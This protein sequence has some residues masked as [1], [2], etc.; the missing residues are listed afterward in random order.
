LASS[1]SVR[2]TFCPPSPFS[3]TIALN[4]GTYPLHSYVRKLYRAAPAAATR[5]LESAPLRPSLASD[6]LVR[7]RWSTRCL[8]SHAHE[9]SRCAR[10]LSRRSSKL[11]QASVRGIS[12]VLGVI[13]LDQHVHTISIS[14]SRAISSRLRE[15]IATKTCR[16]VCARKLPHIFNLDFANKILAGA[17]EAGRR[18]WRFSGSRSSPRST[19][20]TRRN[21]GIWRRRSC[22][23]AKCRRACQRPRWE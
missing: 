9:S 18:R 10:R 5:C 21:S 15:S 20:S 14:S 16:C 22:P 7:G 12:H 11:W 2:R 3:T 23:T 6:L 17:P 1:K 4:V 8:L 19:A 13:F